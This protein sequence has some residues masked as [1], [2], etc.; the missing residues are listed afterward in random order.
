MQKNVA[1]SCKADGS[2]CPSGVTGIPI[3]IVTS[4]L[5][6][7]SF[8]TSS[9]T[10]TDLAQNAVGN[11]AVRIENTTLNAHLR[12]NQQFSSIDYLDDGGDSYYHS[13]Q[14]TMRK[15][16]AGGLLFGATYSFGKSIDDLSS[17]PSGAG[18]SVSS[19]SSATVVDDRSWT[20]NR[21]RSDFDRKH[22]LT[23]NTIYELPFGKGKAMFAHLPRAVD[24]VIGGWSLNGIATVE[25]GEPFSVLSGALTSNS[26]H[27]SYAAL[28]GGT[29]PQ[30]QVQNEAGI[31]GPV[32]FTSATGFALPAPGSNGMGRNSFQG[33]GFWDID[34]S[35]SKGFSLT[36]RLHLTFRAEAFN[37]VN[38]TNFTT[39][40]LN[41]LSANFGQTLSTV[42]SAATRN[43]IQT[44]EPSRV[45][46]LALKLYF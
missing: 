22:V 23:I 12:P 10:L 6:P 43:I 35:A 16:F 7:A 9:T 24:S 42:G 37:L 2:G 45:L 39:G 11:M 44:G 19:T 38:H 3:P 25:S 26:A 32:L 46:Q 8:V 14:A 41:I 31:I 21:A 17:D 27:Q 20:N 4:G 40:N 18:G 29:V 33:P 13:L 5:V 15:R 1:A 34:M 28:S 36:E 30:P